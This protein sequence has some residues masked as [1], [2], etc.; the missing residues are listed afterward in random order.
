MLTDKYGPSGAWTLFKYL[1]QLDL[2]T[3]APLCTAA[4]KVLHSELTQVYRPKAGDE[5]RPYSELLERL[6]AGEPMTALTWLAGHGCDAAAELDDAEAAV[7]A[8][9]DSPGQAE[10]LATL[11]QL[12]RRP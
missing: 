6:G 8:Y 12:H 4:M 11:A 7:R 5:P 1:P 9:Q 3:T 2:E 10:M